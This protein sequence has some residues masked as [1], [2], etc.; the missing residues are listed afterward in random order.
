MLLNSCKCVSPGPTDTEFI[1]A[2]E[3]PKEF[4]DLFSSMPKLEADDVADA[5]LYILST[6]PHVQVQDIM[7]R[8][9]GEPV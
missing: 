8:P 5:V 9:L 1:N 6:P 4:V 7:L 2:E 3:A